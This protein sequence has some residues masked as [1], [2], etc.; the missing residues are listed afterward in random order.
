MKRLLALLLSLLM[1]MSAVSACAEGRKLVFAVEESGT[2]ALNKPFFEDKIT[3]AFPNDTIEFTYFA[4]AKEMQVQVAGGAGPDVIFLSGPTSA[5]AYAKSDRLVSLNAYSEKYGWADIFYEWAYNACLFKG[6]LYSL[7]NSFEGMGIY[8]NMDVLTELDAAIPTTMD[9][10]VALCE[11]CQA[12]GIIPFSYGTSNYIGVHGWTYSM[13]YNCY[14]GPDAVKAGLEATADWNASPLKDAVQL[15]VDW[16][17]KGYFCDCKSQ[18]VSSDDMIPMFAEGETAMMLDGTW[19]TGDLMNLYPDLNWTMD[20]MVDMGKGR[21]VPLAIGGCYAINASCADPDFAAEVLNFIFTDGIDNNIAAV[22]EAGI[23][24]YPVKA[25]TGDAFEGSEAHFVKTYDVLLTAQ[26]ENRIGYCGWCFFPSTVH[27]YLK[28]NM[29]ALYLK[30]MDIE[31][32][33]GD[34]NRL[35]AEEAANGTAPILP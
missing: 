17:Q 16:W 9:E 1:V 31:T 10:L 18:A 24:P 26:A 11:K 7:P 13:L 2:S 20:E 21:I 22:R 19:A 6:E 28:S 3:E 25:V 32:F 27:S 35:C 33:C 23:Q 8:Y 12:N 30:T 14:A 5:M 15:M 4:D 34:L 29:D